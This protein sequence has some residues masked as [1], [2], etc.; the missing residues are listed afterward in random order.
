MEARNTRT[1]SRQTNM[2][3]FADIV[4]NQDESKQRLNILLA[5]NAEIAEQK[6]VYGSEREKM[7]A[8]LMFAPINSEQAFAYF[9]LLLGVFP[10]FAIFLKYFMETGPARSEKLWIFGVALIVS[11]LSAL[12]GYF[13]GKTI[14]RWVRGIETR[15]WGAMLLIAPFIGLL[16]GLTSGAAGG[17]I[18]F[19]VGAI[20]GAVLGGMVGAIA[21]P[22]FTVV[23]RLVKRGEMIDRRHFLPLAF[24]VTFAICSFILGLG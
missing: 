24:G 20:V 4:L 6:A 5:A 1:V 17:I 8:D 23:H 22:A 16:W 13:F 14:G 7:E 12:V 21:L 11:L 3:S 2:T 19:G 9:G 10:P 15:P 18:I